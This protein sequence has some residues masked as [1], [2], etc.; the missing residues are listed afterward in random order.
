MVSHTPPHGTCDWDAREGRGRRGCKA[1]RERL[2]VVRPRLSICGHVHGG[3]G[4]E[5]IVW[6]DG[7][8]DDS[9]G[10][11]D[12][13][14]VQRIEMWKDP[15]EG[16]KKLSLVDLTRRAEG[17]VG[18]WMV[19]TGTGTTWL[20]GVSVNDDMAQEQT[21]PGA[22]LETALPREVVPLPAYNGG[23]P[24]EH[25]PRSGDD[26]APISLSARS[27]STES[28]ALLRGGSSPAFDRAV[29]QVESSH[30]GRPSSA[31]TVVVNAAI[32]GARHAGKTTGAGSNKP[33]V[34][35]LELAVPPYSR[36]M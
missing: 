15:G 23:G 13:E 35:D 2:G 30:V 20:Q 25:Q 11:G 24:R 1:L 29:S 16:S 28:G 27:H 14:T 12:G 5:R 26:S 7:R 6:K 21:Q 19:R 18:Q 10:E 36:V 17:Q 8:A 3:R 4:A 9:D 32:S 33:I 34:V 22:A 31:S